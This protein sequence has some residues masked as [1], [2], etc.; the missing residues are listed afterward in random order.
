MKIT[1]KILL[2]ELISKQKKYIQDVYLLNYRDLNRLVKHIE[3][4]I[5]SNECCIWKGYIIQRNDKFYINFFYKGNKINL[6]RLLYH[7]FVGKLDDS[8]Y[9]RNNCENGGKCCNVNHYIKYISENDINNELS[10]DNISSDD[11]SINNENNIYEEDFKV[12]F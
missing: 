10:D 9:I 5:F 6:S 7:N 3:T 12:I 1:K 11:E 8:E 2:E 4:S